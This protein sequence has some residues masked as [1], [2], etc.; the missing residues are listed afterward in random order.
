M[1]GECDRLL[2]DMKW[3]YENYARDPS[4]DRTQT[5]A[6]QN[7]LD[8]IARTRAANEKAADERITKSAAV[9]LFVSQARALLDAHFTL[10]TSVANLQGAKRKEVMY[11][12]W[13][14]IQGQIERHN[15]KVCAR[16]KHMVQHKV[17]HMVRYSI[18]D[19]IAN[20]CI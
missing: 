19:G 15:A 1:Q 7:M 16:A 2:K 17:Q 10:D 4:N 9:S 5:S 12:V 3:T 13:S 18:W 14:D 20:L 8:L 6:Y 11:E